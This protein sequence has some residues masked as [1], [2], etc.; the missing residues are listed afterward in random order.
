[1]AQ[2]QDEDEI[3]PFLKRP[4]E[5]KESVPTA[6]V[7]P[8]PGPEEKHK[9]NNEVRKSLGMEPTPDL[10]QPLQPKPGAPPPPVPPTPPDTQALLGGMQNNQQPGNQF[11]HPDPRMLA[12]GQMQQGAPGGY[13]PPSPAVKAPVASPVDRGA[14]NLLD[15]LKAEE[16][17]RVTNLDDARRKGKLSLIGEALAGIGQAA[18]SGATKGATGIDLSSFDKQRQDALNNVNAEAD[19]R[20]QAMLTNWATQQQMI[21]AQQEQAAY[22]LQQHIL[23]ESMDPNSEMST[24]SRALF[25]QSLGLPAD[26]LPPFLQGATAAQVG[27]LSPIGAKVTELVGNQLKL[28]SAKDISDARNAATVQAAGMRE[29]GAEQR[30]QEGRDF[31]Q[32]KD[33]KAKLLQLSDDFANFRGNTALQTANSQVNAAE[34]ALG[35]LDKKD[36]T[37]QQQ[38]LAYA[39][40]VRAF[41]GNAPS[42]SQ[43]KEITPET[44]KSK[45]A[46]IM[47]AFTNKPVSAEGAAFLGDMK[48]A[49]VHLHNSKLDAIDQ[50]RDARAN[51]AVTSGLPSEQVKQMREGYRMKK[52]EQ[53]QEQ[54]KDLKDYKVGEKKMFPD[55]IERTKV[56]GGWQ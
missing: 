55:G 36:M 17:S 31:E 35:Y 56:E 26:K 29:R 18:R 20:K 41:T 32:G 47:S 25:A 8:P 10:V 52:L 7:P 14:P 1:M 5:T 24:R 37:P 45:M 39:E 53:Q 49:L 11:A 19:K 23:K 21:K 12:L 46:E 9:V 27:Q 13:Q 15:Y 43:L 3:P 40:V 54:D 28:Q 30:A 42:D 50:A 51:D 16:Q 44:F 4:P 6:S 33:T 34:T 22:Q 38:R 2:Q 48:D